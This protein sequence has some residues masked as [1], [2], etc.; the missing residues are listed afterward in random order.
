[1][2]LLLCDS[3]NSIPFSAQPCVCVCRVVYACVFLLGVF[4][5]LKTYCSLFPM[6]L[7]FDLSQVLMFGG[8][9]GA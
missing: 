5:Q 6:V 2:V 1:M 9:I 8:D 3:W 7:C 4:F